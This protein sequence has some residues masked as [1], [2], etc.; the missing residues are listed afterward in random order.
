MSTPLATLPAESSV[1]CD[2]LVSFLQRHAV[3]F[4]L[5]DH[6]PTLT[7]A[8]SAAVRGATLASGA[9]AMLLVSPTPL[10]HGGRYILAVLAADRAANWN[11]LKK[12]LGCKKL[13]LASTEE[14]VALTGCLPGA[15]PPFGS[16]FDGVCTV[17]DDSLLLQGDV[18]N[19]NAGLRT[20]SVVNLRVADYVAIEKPRVMQFAAAVAAIAPTDG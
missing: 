12:G 1:T 8:E 9:K 17:L 2:K 10:S 18:C 4:V 16:L 5:L 6:A 15:V 3:A 13:T 11:A 19:F 7:S 14:L 20:R